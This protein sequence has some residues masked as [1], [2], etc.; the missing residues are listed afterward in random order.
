TDA[1]ASGNQALLAHGLAIQGSLAIQSG[2]AALPMLAEAE[3]AAR[4]SSN[5]YALQLALGAQG[6][7]AM[8]AGQAKAAE[9]QF[10]EQ[11]AICAAN[12]IPDGRSSA[13]GNLAVVLQQ[14]GDSAGALAALVEQEDLCRQM[15]DAQNLVLCLAN[16]GEVTSGLPGRKAE[17]LGVLD[18]AIALAQQIGWAP[19]AGQIHQ[20][21]AQLEA[22]PG[23]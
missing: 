13:L 18:Q 12:A 1:R 7:L 21:R 22:R 15:N 9:A 5:P 17:G 10:R 20:L 14:Q 19:M 23:A 16:R 6:V 8:Q 3:G 11:A 2:P 4:A